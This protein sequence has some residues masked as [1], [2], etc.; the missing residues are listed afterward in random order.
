YALG[1][2]LE[3]QNAISI[4][5][6]TG[7]VAAFYENTGDNL[8]VE[9]RKGVESMLSTTGLDQIGG[10][11]EILNDTFAYKPGYSIA[12]SFYPELKN[13]LEVDSVWKIVESNWDKC[14]IDKDNAYRTFPFDRALF[15][16]RDISPDQLSVYFQDLEK[17]DDFAKFVA[18]INYEDSK[19]SESIQVD[20]NKV[21][22]KK[23][24]LFLSNVA[25]VISFLLILFA[26]ASIGLFINNLVRNHLNKVKMNLGTFKAMGLHNKESVSIYF[27]IILVF[28]FIACSFG[29]L[30][31]FIAGV[32]MN[33]LLVWSVKSDDDMSYFV[34]FNNNTALAFAFV[35]GISSVISYRTIHKIL[36]KSPGDL[37]YNR[38]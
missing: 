21:K 7:M 17:I 10:T 2:Q 13:Y 6:E 33:E 28:F 5:S 22:D 12:I 26:T 31:A 30:M 36:S 25:Y 8:N 1:N 11:V 18:R 14:G 23:N 16:K 29:F 3:S 37:I 32:S 35:L 9:M 24:F 15:D 38:G 4:K 34:L 20:Q 27:R 19:N